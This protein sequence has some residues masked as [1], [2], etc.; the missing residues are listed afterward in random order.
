MLKAAVIGVGAMGKNHARI[1]SEIDG[2]KLVA[3]SDTDKK[4]LAGI[5]S[6]FNVKGYNDYKE[7]LAKEKLDIV[8]IAVPTFLHKQ[9]AIDA[10]SIGI[11]VLLEK[12][13]ATSISDA[14][15]IIKN[16]E[17]KKIKL[18]IGHIERF[19]PAIIELKRRIADLGDIY[20]IIVER[21]GPFPQRITDVGVVIDLSVHDLDII[22][23]L[24]GSKLETIYAETQQRIHPKFEDS[25]T[26][27]LKY[28]NNVISVLNIDWLTPTKKRQLT[29][30][31]RKGMFK[32]NYLTQ[33]IYFYENRIGANDY[34]Y[35]M[36]S[37]TEGNMTKIHI[38]TKEPLKQE[39]Q[40]FVDCVVQ[41]KA[42]LITGQDGI[43]ALL[44]AQKI[45]ESA[46]EHKIVKL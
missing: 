46:H 2:V 27:I 13:I 45:L 15:E 20:K 36:V 23:Y 10:I 8:S 44:S 32:I 42:P 16:A 22:N 19:N 34:G 33:E 40:S 43:N 1:Y 21:V 17:E 9:V 37:V 41:N 25:L 6:K 35:G 24:L 29:V 26:A 28:Q 30:T 38:D 39:I 3:V 5:C 7:M 12:P 18:M 11:N 14:K 4:S 31:G